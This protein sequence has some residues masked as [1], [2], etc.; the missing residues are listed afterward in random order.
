MSWSWTLY[1]DQLTAVFM[2]INVLSSKSFVS[3][4]V[5]HQIIDRSSCQN[6]ERFSKMKLSAYDPLKYKYI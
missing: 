4:K 3:F 6:K 1:L 2:T 5:K